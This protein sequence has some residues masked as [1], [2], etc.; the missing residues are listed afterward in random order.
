MDVDRRS[1]LNACLGIIAFLHASASLAQTEITKLLLG[2]KP[3]S[4]INRPPS[5]DTFLLLSKILTAKSDLNLEF[6]K[7][8]YETFLTEPW[9]AKH[10]NTVIQVIRRVSDDNGGGFDLH[11]AMKEEQFEKNERWFISH[12][13]FT[14]FTGVY[15]YTGRDKRLSFQYALIHEV[16]ADIH[17]TPTFSKQSHGFWAELPTSGNG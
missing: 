15:Y 12:L 16:L 7:K 14:W 1:F 2:L 5:F 11:V 8:I 4:D 3:E 17:T 10:F 9:S 6:A 13:L